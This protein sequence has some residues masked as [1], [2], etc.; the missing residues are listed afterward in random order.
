MRVR[1]PLN[2]DAWQE[3]HD[4]YAPVV[5][6]YCRQRR[7]QSSDVE[8]VVQDVM[9]LV[10]KAIRYFDY[11]PK[12][13]RFRSW[14]GTVAANRIK[15]FL[16][17]E[18]RRDEVSSRLEIDGS[19]TDPDTDWVAIFSERILSVACSRI[20]EEFQPVTW[21]CFESSWLRNEPAALIARKMEIPIHSVYVNKSRVLKRLEIEVKHLAEDVAAPKH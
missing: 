21:Q 16:A 9:T 3:F 18:A 1:D 12:V 6:S 2:V 20:R 15:T 11:D 5:R 17:K 14:F 10:A 4:I 7:L 8:D 19:Y 13:G